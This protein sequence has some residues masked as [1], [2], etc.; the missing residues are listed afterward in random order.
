MAKKHF[1]LLKGK[2]YAI[3][4]T[5]CSHSSLIF[6]KNKRKN[7]YYILVFDSSSGR[8]RTKLYHPI[9]ENVK[10]SYIQ[11]R[12]LIVVKKEFGNHELLG[13]NISKDDR[14]LL[15]RIK[16][17]KPRLSRKYKQKNPSRLFTAD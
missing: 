10:V 17:R 7:K 16:R 5:G 1:K 11:N 6:R 12:P 14:I 2:F 3:Y 9:S 8:H 4:T 13:L 15:K